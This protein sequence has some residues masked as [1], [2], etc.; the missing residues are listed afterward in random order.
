LA[1]KEALVNHEFALLEEVKNTISTM[2]TELNNFANYIAWF[3]LYTSNAIF[4]SENKLVKSEY[5]NN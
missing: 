1:A 4:A 5:Q 3:D 2:T